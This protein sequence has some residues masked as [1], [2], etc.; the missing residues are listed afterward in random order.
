MNALPKYIIAD[1]DDTF[2]VAGSLSPEVLV[3]VSRAAL[4]GIE[5]ILNTGR[6]AGYGAT[7]FAYLSAVSAV[8][9]ENGGAFFDRR[10]A[11]PGQDPREVAIQPVRGFDA[12]L[13]SRLQA[14]AQRTATRA[15]LTFTETAD[16]PFRLTDFTVL[17][18]LPKSD[19]AAILRH[20]AELVDEESSG[21]GSLLASSIHIHFMLDGKGAARSKADGCLA[22]LQ[23]RGFSAEAAR[24]ELA[25]HAITVG[26]SANDASFFTPGRFAFSVGV[27]N[28][29]RYLGELGEARPRHIT[30]Q[31]EGL[32]LV[33]FIDE[34]LDKRL[35][36]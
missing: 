26:D 32:G 23:R 22:L 15:G 25:T 1:V 21:S 5:V 34:V 7:L 18:Q 19:A 36:W 6:P 2:T 12:T 35:P 10:D 3:A 29:E 13:R 20:L 27:R 14:L 16:N 31:H 8:I 4:A 28:I 30:R 17:R 33:E 11:Q 24:N 9:V